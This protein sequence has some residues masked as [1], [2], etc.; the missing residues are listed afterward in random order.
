MSS[1]ARHS[2]LQTQR[3]SAEAEDAAAR[4]EMQALQ[5]Q[6][7]KLSAERQSLYASMSSMPTAPASLRG[8]QLHSAFSFKTGHHIMQDYIEALHGIIGKDCACNTCL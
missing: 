1:A 3:T 2:Q 5:E 8:Q 7:C 6:H 4:A